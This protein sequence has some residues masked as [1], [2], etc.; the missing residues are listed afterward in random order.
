M[1]Q[2]R[3]F[4]NTYANNTNSQAIASI[5]LLKNALMTLMR[6]YEFESITVTQLAQEAKVTRQTF[7]RNF[8]SNKDVLNYYFHELLDAFFISYDT[9][10]HINESI[11]SLF[12]YAYQNKEELSVVYKNGLLHELDESIQTRIKEMLFNSY[13]SKGNSPRENE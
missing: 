4:C 10:Q 3:G 12:Y 13:I 7:Y 6:T 11:A 1:R 5:T 9:Q 8:D 2:F